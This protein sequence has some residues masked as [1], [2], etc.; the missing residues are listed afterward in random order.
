[1][2]LAV[3]RLSYLADDQLVSLYRSAVEMMG[4]ES[5]LVRFPSRNIAEAV[6]GKCRTKLERMFG[7]AVIELCR[8]PLKGDGRITPMWVTRTIPK[9]TSAVPGKK[10]KTSTN[11]ET[12][13]SLYLLC[14]IC[15]KRP[16][17]RA[18][19]I[20]QI[21][22]SLPGIGTENPP[23]GENF[24]EEV[25]ELGFPRRLALASLHWDIEHGFVRLGPSLAEDTPS[26]DEIESPH[27]GDVANLR[28]EDVELQEPADAAD[29]AA[30][31]AL[32]PAELS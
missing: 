31:T 14:S 25:V 29:P 11:L 8:T 22:L 26:R 4:S 24:L 15:P 27:S 20:Y 19:E 21:Y 18:W 30:T 2:G 5:G 12:T 23:T 7:Y 17:T 9:L 32:E 3:P 6:I 1:M 10:K 16:G 28:R 13:Q